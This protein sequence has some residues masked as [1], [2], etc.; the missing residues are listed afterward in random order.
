MTAP[1]QT[2][3]GKKYPVPTEWTRAYTAPDSSP[4]AYPPARPS[5]LRARGFTTL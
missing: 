3:E 5:K 2:P 4:R 1:A